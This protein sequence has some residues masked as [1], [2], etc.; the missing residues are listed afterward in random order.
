[1]KLD[2]CVRLAQLAKQT[3]VTFYDIHNMGIQFS[4][5]DA[6]NIVLALAVAY[7]TAFARKQT[8]MVAI[9]TD[10]DAASIQSVTY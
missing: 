3:T 2:A 6:Q 10:S 4:I 7:Q 9:E 5:A 1:M 8:A